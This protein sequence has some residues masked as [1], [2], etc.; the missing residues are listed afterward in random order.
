LVFAFGVP[1]RSLLLFSPNPQARKPI[2]IEINLLRKGC[3]TAGAASRMALSGT[4]QFE[5]GTG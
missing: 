3:N 5:G 1:A 2:T 4:T